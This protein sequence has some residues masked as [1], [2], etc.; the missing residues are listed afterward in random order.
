MRNKKRPFPDLNELAFS[1]RNKEYGSYLLRKKYPKHLL[2]SFIFS[3]LIFFLLAIV[4]YLIYF[5][6]TAD[7]NFDDRELYTVEYNFIPS[8]EEDLGT[9]A[10]LLAKPPP[11]AEQVPVVVDSVVDKEIKK[12]P[13][14]NP[15]EKTEGQN[16]NSDT[17]SYSRGQSPDGQGSQDGHGIYTILDVYPKYP[18]GDQ[19]R[20]FYLRSSIKYPALALKMGIQGEVMVLFVIEMDGSISNVTINKGIGRGCDEEAIRVTKGMPRWEPGRRSG[21]AV[22]VLVRMPIVFKIPGEKK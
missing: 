2:F 15:E 8:P 12:P 7:M 19:A 9:L 13:E 17:A 3:V 5:L 16:A 4:P 18:G 1:G 22:R 20:L 10:R 11:T 6:D 14:E 21:K